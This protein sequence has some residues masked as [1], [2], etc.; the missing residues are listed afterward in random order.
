VIEK[1]NDNYAA[2]SP[3]I[4]GCIATGAT[5]EETLALMKEALVFHLEGMAEDGETIPAPKGIDYHLKQGVFKPGAIA[6]E[7]FITEL[8]LTLPQHA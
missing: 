8:S 1:A 6:D 3:D 5:V 4:P 2:F 7:Y